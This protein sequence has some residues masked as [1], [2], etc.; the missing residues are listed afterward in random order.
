MYW[1]QAGRLGTRTNQIRLRTTPTIRIVFQLRPSRAKKPSSDC[2]ISST[3]GGLRS[4]TVLMDIPHQR[5]SKS[6][7]A[8]ESIEKLSSS[9]DLDDFSVRSHGKHV[10][11]LFDHARTGKA[12]ATD[13][14]E[15][16]AVAI[17][18]RVATDERDLVV[19]GAVLFGIVEPLL[20]NLLTDSLRRHRLD[21][22]RVERIPLELGVK[23][24]HALDVLVDRRGRICLDGARRR[25]RYH[26]LTRRIHPGRGGRSIGG[27]APSKT[28][29]VAQPSQPEANRTERKHNH[30]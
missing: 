19:L 29:R 13:H 3:W 11:N 10:K 12:A 20:Q 8:T 27:G 18:Q 26:R 2:S 28:L 22:S 17:F 1:P 4:V 16:V 9:F 21:G 7:C 5:E 14:V 6:R 25:H 30:D 15:E 24:R 23:R